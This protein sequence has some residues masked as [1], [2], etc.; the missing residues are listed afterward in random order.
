MNVSHNIETEFKAKQQGL[1]GLYIYSSSEQKLLLQV[2]NNTCTSF[3]K[4]K[5]S[6]G[7]TI[8]KVPN[9]FSRKCTI[10]D[11]SK[12]NVFL[13]CKLNFF[14]NKTEV[15][16]GPNRD[17]LPRFVVEV[18]RRGGSVAISEAQFQ[19]TI[20]TLSLE[21]VFHCLYSMRNVTLHVD[22]GYDVP[23]MILLMMTALKKQ[24]QKQNSS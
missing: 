6:N 23:L 5:D 20:A 7:G 24:K 17:S 21:T 14:S 9:H 12:Q 2:P 19:K 10:T 15:W 13:S 3:C 18:S 8:Y 11:R 1:K 16:L 4:I 22:A